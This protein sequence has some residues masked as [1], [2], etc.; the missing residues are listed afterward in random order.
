MRPRDWNGMN[1]SRFESLQDTVYWKARSAMGGGQLGQTM[2]SFVCFARERC[3]AQLR[4]IRAV[5]IMDISPAKREREL[6]SHPCETAYDPL[7]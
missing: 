6:G 1:M 4:P 5:R 7:S 3:G 2:T